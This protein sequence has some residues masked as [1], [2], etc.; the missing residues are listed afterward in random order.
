MSLLLSI[1]VI[2]VSSVVIYFAGKYF[3]GASSAIGDYFRIPRDVKGATFDAVSSSM[4]ELLVALYSVI[5]F[6]QFEVGIGT[7]AG[8]ALFNL[9]VIPGICVFLA[10]VV[11]KI[12]RRVISRDAL[13]YMVAVFV[14][15]VLIIY[16]KKWGLI[17]SLVLLG[18]YLIYVLQIASHTK[19]HRRETKKE[20]KK[21]ISIGKQILI[22]VS[23]LAVIGVFT[24]LLTHYSIELSEILKVSP[25]IIA[26]TI[27]AAATSLPDAVISAVNAKK[28]DVNDSASNIFGSNIFDIFVGLGLPLLIYTVIKGAVEITFHNLEIVLGLLFTTI[29]SLY[30]FLNDDI[31]D[32]KE[33]F[34]L[35]LLY[36]LFIV[37]VIL[38]SFNIF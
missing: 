31:L 29:L 37:Y 8:S 3:A 10:P 1:G 38:L 30:F 35:I 36:V 6:K 20:K 21:E 4:P 7:I 5:V 26:F 25:I 32:K 33:A 15:I 28:G 11:F 2:I 12:G 24:Y 27:T 34:V 22:F 13:F 19:K 17:I 18:I 23:M 14:L 9:L 16:F